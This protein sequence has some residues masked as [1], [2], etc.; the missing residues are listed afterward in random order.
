LRIALVIERFE[1]EAGGVE[2][3]AW[4]V[5]HRLAHAGEEIHVIARRA[6]PP[7]ALRGV[8]VHRVAA[9][10]AWQPLRV[11]AFS[12]GAA[13]RA[14]AVGAD[15]VHSFSR[16]RH[17][18]LYRAGGGSHADFLARSY[19][20]WGRALRRVSPRH[21]VLI[22]IERRVFADPHQLIQCNSPMVRAEIAARYPVPPERLVVLPNGV[23]LE[24][25]HPRR[26]ADEGA[27]L[28]DELDAKDR[29]VW[30]LVGNGLW[31]KGLDTALGALARAACSD[32]ELWV[33][34]RDDPEPWRGR[35][36]S[37]GLEG[38]VRFLGP[39]R[40][41]QAVY[42]AGD[43]LLLPTRYDAFAN[44]TLEAA[45]AGIPV[46]TSGANGAA[47]LLREAGLVVEDPED[48]AGFAT[49]LDSL[50][51]PA[52]R[53]ALGRRAREKA[54]GLSWDRHVEALRTLYRRVHARSRM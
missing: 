31:R 3:V 33:A 11:L 50:A 9:P 36:R 52:A 49:A 37:L 54:E 29:V 51:D 53:A 32:T 7:D 28:R 45:A 10:A 2:G 42:A 39:R 41:I 14:R 1:P 43:A 25:F 12:R 35:V 13:A 20:P 5:A 40:D 34:G 30:V 23:D 8:E 18:D 15:V 16:T 17:Q 19:G 44:A 4:T 21:R 48:V 6:A 24:R 22:G 27:R 47:D 38:R 46:V 26:R